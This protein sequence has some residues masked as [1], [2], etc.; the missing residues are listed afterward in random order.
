[1]KKLCSV[2]AVFGL[3]L[4]A[5]AAWSDLLGEPLKLTSDSIYRS[6]ELNLRPTAGLYVV[7]MMLIVSAIIGGL[8][9]HSIQAKV[10]IERLKHLD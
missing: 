5:M 9:S 8:I 2:F 3:M 10:E 4:I 7:G 6:T 1:M